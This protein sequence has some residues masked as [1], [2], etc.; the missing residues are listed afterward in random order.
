MSEPFIGEIRL[1]AFLYAPRYWADCDGQLLPVDQHTSLF[2]LLGTTYGGNGR[3]D[4]ALPDLRGRVP[5]HEGQGVGSPLYR[6]GQTGGYPEVSLTADQVPPHTHPLRGKNDTPNELALG[7]HSLANGARALYS[8]QAPD[9][10]LHPDSVGPSSGGGQ[11]H[12]NMQPYL[13]LRFCI[14]LEGLYPPRT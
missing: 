4:F 6:Q 2:S 1:F 12:Y 13:T 5:I 8:D 3:T 9:T 14:A 11:P 7:G 10:Q